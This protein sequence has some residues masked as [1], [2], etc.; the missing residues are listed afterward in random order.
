VDAAGEL[1][2]QHGYDETTTAAIAR[3]A[4][5]AV[6]TVYGYFPDK[7]AILLEIVHATVEQMAELVLARL[8]P[9]LWRD[10]DPRESLRSLIHTIFTTRELRPGLQR[11]VWE[12]FFK[13]DEVRAAL[14][15]IESRLR[16]AVCVL[17]V[18]LEEW[19]LG[20]VRDPESAAFVI[21][22]SVEWT[23]SRLMLGGASD[24]EVEAAVQTTADMIAALILGPA[25]A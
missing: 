24:G 5:V 18:H 14:E 15:S 22:T 10:A 16:E 4:R 19:G 8:D 1:F 25:P 17:L 9:E 7:R 2:E 11:I 20:R 23:A 13:D 6:G 3:R 21:H 12:R